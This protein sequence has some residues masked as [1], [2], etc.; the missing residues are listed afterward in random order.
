MIN[1]IPFMGKEKNLA[2]PNSQKNLGRL[3]M[4]D[5]VG[6]GKD[7]F[8]TENGENQSL[9]NKASAAVPANVKA[10]MTVFGA[11]VK[12]KIEEKTGD[13]TKPNYI[14]MGI[15]FA[16]GC[17]FLLAAFT[18]L[19]FILISPAGFNMYFS[20]FSTSML[21]SVSFYYGPLNYMKQLFEKKNIMISMLFILSTVLSLMTIF[22]RAGYLWS[23]GLVII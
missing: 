13:L 4:I 19:P 14:W 5:S 21:I 7:D 6:L 17:L 8:D 2:D 11:S 12:G 1:Y 15:F 10:K 16:I 20:L 9:I 23:I 22:T 3:D 18:S